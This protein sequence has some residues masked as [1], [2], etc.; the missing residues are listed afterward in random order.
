MVSF[1]G[2]PDSYSKF[3]CMRRYVVGYFEKGCRW[4]LF[5]KR[6]RLANTKRKDLGIGD[7][8]LA[9]NAVHVRSSGSRG[10]W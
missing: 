2:C 7:F 3:P 9:S 8:W 10:T 4:L 5:E 6:I 1:A